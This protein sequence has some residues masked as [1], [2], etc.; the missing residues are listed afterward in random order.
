MLVICVSFILLLFGEGGAVDC[1]DCKALSK[2]LF[3]NP[4]DK[5][6]DI[7][8]C[9]T[10]NGEKDLNEHTSNAEMY[11][12]LDDMHSQLPEITHLWHIGDSVEGLP[13]VDFIISDKPQYHE[14]LEPEFKYVAN[15]HGNEVVGRELLIDLIYYLLVNYGHNSTITDLV[16]NT[17]IHILVTM[18]PDGYARQDG[19]DWL[20]GRSNANDVDLN[21]DFP[22]MDTAAFE[23]LRR[24]ICK[25]DQLDKSEFAPA[26]NY[27]KLQPETLAIVKW[28][29][30]FPFSLSANL[31]GGSFVANYPYDIANNRN[32]SK[33]P[34]NKLFKRLASIYSSSHSFMSENIPEKKCAGD[35]ENFPNGITNGAEWYPVPGGMQDYNYDT[36]NDFEITL[37]LGCDKSPKA[38]DMWMYWHQNKDSLINFIDA[39]HMGVKGTVKDIYGV[40]LSGVQVTAY[41]TESTDDY[42]PLQCHSVYTTEV[43]DF[44]RLLL[45]GVYRIEFTLPGYNEPIAT[46]TVEVDDEVEIVEIRI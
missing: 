37:E 26:V 11:N 31:H 5:S 19:K 7:T 12:F 46:K 36:S 30:T 20:L 14:E 44:F 16:D 45:P 22:N 43:G 23:Y 35:D 42:P 28:L 34:D 4:N 15:M 40:P 13:L 21:R 32:M 38:E 10:I 2:A 1:N 27:E 24:G 3:V 17:R 25:T 29:K 8:H 41:D 33:T 9:T 6:C 18:N 39:V